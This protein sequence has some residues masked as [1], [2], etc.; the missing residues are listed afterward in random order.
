MLVMVFDESVADPSALT[1]A[2]DGPSPLSGPA[3]DGHTARTVV[4][5]QSCGASPTA[6]TAA[7]AEDTLPDDTVKS[8]RND[9]AAPVTAVLRVERSSGVPAVI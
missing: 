1:V 8:T 7:V 3:P 9:G 6:C 5:R 4:V 2:E